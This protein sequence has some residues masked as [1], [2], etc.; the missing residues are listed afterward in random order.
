[1]SKFL[2]DELRSA[3]D[4]GRISR[5]WKRHPTFGLDDFLQLLHKFTIGLKTI[6]DMVF[7][8]IGTR[9]KAV[10]ERPQC[11]RTS[12]KICGRLID[13]QSLNISQHDLPWAGDNALRGLNIVLGAESGAISIAFV[14]RRNTTQDQTAGSKQVQQLYSYTEH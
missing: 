1:M 2:K 9:L 11:L 14:T 4:H 13:I 6:Y 3:S 5:K 12:Q 7:P 10:F 8:V